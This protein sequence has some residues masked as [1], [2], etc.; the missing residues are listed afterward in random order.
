MY[1]ILRHQK[2]NECKTG[3]VSRSLD[4]MN[5]FTGQTFLFILQSV[6]LQEKEKSWP[7]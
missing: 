7:G 3:E 6:N 2:L 4:I 1:E 5:K